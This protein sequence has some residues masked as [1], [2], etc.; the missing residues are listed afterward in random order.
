M[1]TLH[2]PYGIASWQHLIAHGGARPQSRWRGR[3]IVSGRRIASLL[4]RIPAL[5]LVIAVG[6]GRSGHAEIFGRRRNAA[7][8]SHFRRRRM[9]AIR[10]FFLYTSGTTSSPKAVSVTFNH[11]PQ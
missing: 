8:V 9:R 4:G 6:G 2:T 3:R 1:Q 5:Q 10:F 7:A 11:F